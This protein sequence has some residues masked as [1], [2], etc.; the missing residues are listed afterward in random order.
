M[1]SLV[2]VA[3]AI[4]SCSCTPAPAPVTPPPFDASDAAPIPVDADVYAACCAKM[5]D[6][7]PNCAAVLAQGVAAKLVAIPTACNLCN[8]ACP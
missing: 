3:L 1:R 2:W 8:L 5:G 4:A 7:A 6:T